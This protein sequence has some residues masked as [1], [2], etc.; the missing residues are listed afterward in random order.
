MDV[1]LRF[2]Q[3]RAVAGAPKPTRRLGAALLASAMV[4]SVL[5]GC[6][7]GAGESAGSGSLPDGSWIDGPPPEDI[8]GPDGLTTDGI[9]V[10]PEMME[11]SASSDRSGDAAAGDAVAAVAPSALKAGHIDDNDDFEGFLEYLDRVRGI[12]VPFREMDP[13]GRV[14]ITVVDPDRRPAAGAEVVVSAGG[15]EVAR[16]RTTADGTALFHPRAYGVEDSRFTVA[17]GGSSAEA[18]AGSAV[19]LE[20]S[21]AWRPE[22]VPLDIAFA[23]DTT[24]SMGDELDR[25]KDSITSVVDRIEDLPGAPDVRL[26]MTVYR[27]EGDAYVTATHDFTGDVPAFREELAALSADGGGDQPEALDEALAEVLGAPAWRDPAEAIQLVF[28]VGD[29][30]GHPERDVE[31]PYVESMRNASERGVKI[32]PIAASSSDDRAEVAFRQL[33][34]FTGAPFVFLAYGAGGAA[35]GGSTDIDSTD[36]EELSLD[37]L[38]V[39]LVSEELAALSGGG[40][41]PATVPPTVTTTT[42]TNPPGQ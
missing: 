21:S 34:Q 18:Q 23:I 10:M 8:E 20:V 19:S 42:T 33:A 29:A 6:G 30:G 12:G 13:S 38:I 28:V 17:S 1:G 9:E 36:Y 35:T 15:E 27:D 25:L 2:G 31:Q 39:R 16:I 3:Q 14:V 4:G 41:S 11:D 5:V 37:D 24:G 7:A 26:A 32:L 40:S 22:R